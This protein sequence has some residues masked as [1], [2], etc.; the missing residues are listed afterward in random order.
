MKAWRHLLLQVI[1]FS[2]SSSY[3]TFVVVI[4]T[5]EAKTNFFSI[6]QFM[7]I[8]IKCV[9]FFLESETTNSRRGGGRENG[10]EHANNNN[11]STFLCLSKLRTHCIFPRAFNVMSFS[12]CVFFFAVTSN[13]HVHVMLEILF[14]VLLLFFAWVQKPNIFVG[15][16][17]NALITIGSC[18]FF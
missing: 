4:T 2:L 17:S 13:F 18:I 1:Q 14:L 7:N 15:A 16:I 3:Y 6:M 5:T 9:F 10:I 12:C 8:R 11:K